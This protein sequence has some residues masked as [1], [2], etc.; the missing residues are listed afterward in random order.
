MVDVCGD[1][2]ERGAP[3]HGAGQSGANPWCPCR[4]GAGLGAWGPG[5]S[6]VGAVSDC[7]DGGG[8]E[9]ADDVGSGE[10]VDEWTCG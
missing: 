6:G 7:I 10:G 3:P 9:F 1:V 8:A 2:L 4:Y 5:G